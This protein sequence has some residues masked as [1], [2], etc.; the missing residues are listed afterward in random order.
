MKIIEPL[1]SKALLSGWTVILNLGAGLA[2][3]PYLGTEP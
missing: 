3:R 1:P 2:T